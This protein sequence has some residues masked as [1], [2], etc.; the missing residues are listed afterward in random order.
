MNLNNLK[1]ILIWATPPVTIPFIRYAYDSHVHKEPERI[2]LRNERLSQDLL[3]YS[4][5]SGIYL[6]L[7]EGLNALAKNASKADPKKAFAAFGVAMPAY[8][9][10]AGLGALKMTEMI[11]KNKKPIAEKSSDS[12]E[13]TTKKL[14]I[15]TGLATPL[16]KNLRMSNNSLFSSKH[17]L[18]VRAKKVSMVNPSPFTVFN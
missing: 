12:A 10:F 6:G 5:G 13:E 16:N 3:T 9:L 14:D 8:L 11:C 18:N 15:N 7:Y 1:D 4:V 17:T 2:P